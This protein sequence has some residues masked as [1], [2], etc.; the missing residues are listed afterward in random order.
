[1]P[2]I[3]CLSPSPSARVTIT[4]DLG[5]SL[6]LLPRGVIYY[7][8]TENH[9]LQKFSHK[10]RQIIHRLFTTYTF[11]EEVDYDGHLQVFFVAE[12]LILQTKG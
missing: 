8:H 4:C 10:T 1:M 11:V 7:I 6:L 3:T 5:H 2:Q 12:E 9:A